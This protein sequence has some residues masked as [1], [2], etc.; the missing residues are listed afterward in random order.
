MD[1]YKDGMIK[2]ILELMLVLSFENHNGQYVENDLSPQ[3]IVSYR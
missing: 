3:V 1:G 2:L